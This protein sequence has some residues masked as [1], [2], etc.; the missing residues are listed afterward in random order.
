MVLELVSSDDVILNQPLGDFDFSNPLV[1]PIELANQLIETMVANKGLGLSA[2]QCGLPYR[3]FVMHSSP[4]KVCFNPRIVTASHEVSCMEEG[5][6]SHPNLFLK[7]KR[8]TRIKVRYQDASGETF[9]EQ[10]V[11]MTA[12]IFLHEFD[13]MEGKNFITRA[14]PLHVERARR[15]QKKIN[16][17]LKMMK[18]VVIS[19]KQIE[20]GV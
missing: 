4:T 20:K 1:N 19:P 2:N 5:C 6:L 10:F 8:P 18:R 16:R 14:N 7:I 15:E 17:Q 9:T 3:V 11:G 13:H 12:R